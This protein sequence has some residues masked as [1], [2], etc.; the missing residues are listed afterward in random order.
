MKD[1]NRE[2]TAHQRRI[3]MMRVAGMTSDEVGS[4][5]GIA[6]STVRN[7]LTII[8]RKIGAKGITGATLWAVREGLVDP[9]EANEKWMS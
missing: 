4:W 9:E 6:G 1:T 2:L 7:T 5:L 8:Y 3:L